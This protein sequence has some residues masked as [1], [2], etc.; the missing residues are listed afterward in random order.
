MFNSYTAG[1]LTNILAEY[2]TVSFD[3]FD[4]LV[5]R[6]FAHPH[7]VFLRTAKD[8]AEE[9]GRFIEPAKFQRDRIAAEQLAHA[10]LT[11]TQP[12]LNRN[13]NK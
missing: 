4:T 5:K 7:D 9:S 6:C 3:I 2:D 10:I 8:F 11:A 13:S 12:Q 1:R